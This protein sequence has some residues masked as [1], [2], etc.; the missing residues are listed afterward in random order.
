[1][2]SSNDAQ[3]FQA[4]VVGAGPAGLT[5]IGNLIE[6][7]FERISWIDPSFNGGRLNSSYRGV[8]SNTKVKTFLDFAEALQCFKSKLLD[9]EAE[10]E[11]QTTES[12]VAD[13][14]KAGAITAMRALDN[15][16][17]CTLSYAADMVLLLTRIMMKNNKIKLIRTKVIEILQTEEK[18][19]KISSR[20]S[21]I[22]Y[23]NLI[24]KK[25]FLP[26]PL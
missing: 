11:E 20:K 25:R 3:C 17:G 13:N 26:F 14:T 15:D 9:A 5:V 2:P 24:K 4:T 6:Q 22:F 7:N 16:K 19:T 18:V 10:E 21:L 23:F 8:P 1:M 12:K